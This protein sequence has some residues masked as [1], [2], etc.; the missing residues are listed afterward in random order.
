L[1]AFLGTQAQPGLAK[2]RFR[3]TLDRLTAQ[4]FSLAENIALFRTHLHPTLG[5]ASEILLG[6][7]RHR[8]PPVTY[9]LA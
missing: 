3:L 6:C 7:R 1:S 8:K 9:A 5:V 2:R 4:I